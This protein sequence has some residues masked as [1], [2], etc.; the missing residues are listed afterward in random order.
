MFNH[1][2]KNRQFC[3]ME[4]CLENAQS[5]LRFDIFNIIRK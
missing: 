5:F 4:Y 1:S 3:R 2:E